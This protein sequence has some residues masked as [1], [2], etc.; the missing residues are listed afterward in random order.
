MY[1]LMKFGPPHNSELLPL[2]AILQ[3]ESPAGAVPFPRTTPHQHLRQSATDTI[4]RRVMDWTAYSLPYSVAA[5][6]K[7]P[8]LQICKHA[9][10]V[11]LSAS[12]S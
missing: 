3:L 11:M 9:S 2:Q 1:R 8:F 12:M 10:A 6:G 4:G 7:F 5:I